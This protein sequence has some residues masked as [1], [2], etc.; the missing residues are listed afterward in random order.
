[1][2]TR[3]S[4][5]ARYATVRDNFIF[6]APPLFPER[7]PVCLMQLFSNIYHLFKLSAKIFAANR[8]NG[9]Y[10]RHAQKIAQS[11]I[12]QSARL[13]DGSVGEKIFKKTQWYMVSTLFMGELLAGLLG[14]KL[15]ENDEKALVFLGAAG[16]LADALIDDYKL[17]KAQMLALLETDRSPGKTAIEK[18][19]QL[20]L[21]S[22]M[23]CLSQEKTSRMK[24]HVNDLFH[25]QAESLKQFGTGLSEEQV[26]AITNGKGG[27][28]LLLCVVVLSDEDSG[29]ET[30]VY[31]LGG[32]IQLMNDT[33]DIYKDACDGICTFVSF[34]TGYSEVFS[35]LEE[36][37]QAC[38]RLIKALN[39]SKANKSRFL[40][41]F[42]A[43]YIGIVFKLRHYTRLTSGNLDLKEISN[44]KKEDFRVATFSAGSLA[45]CIPKIM[46]FN[47]DTV[48]RLLTVQF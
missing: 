4:C 39:Y 11:Q 33:Q 24:R 9:A 16:G 46:R 19:Y 12:L 25:W 1:M 44:R 40:F 13:N 30:A 48:E 20:Y 17:G 37:K 41:C 15:T 45:F 2:P 36:K 18:I 8:E 6:F 23:R 47:Y 43:M 22:L 26:E 38:F 28:F 14:R 35:F 27:L 29:L 7:L 3:L 32:F 5:P 10:H 42:Y 21:Y 31:R 34:K